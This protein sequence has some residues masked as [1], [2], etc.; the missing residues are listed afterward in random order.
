[1]IEKFLET[2]KKFKVNNF[3]GGQYNYSIIDK[4]FK[5][6]LP[7]TLKYSQ[8]RRKNGQTIIKKYYLIIKK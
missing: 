6:K 2:L 8:S 1:M 5:N 4:I 3:A 7:N